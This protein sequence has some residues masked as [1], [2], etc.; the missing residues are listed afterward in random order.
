MKDRKKDNSNGQSESYINFP[1]SYYIHMYVYDYNSR[2]NSC[3]NNPIPHLFKWGCTK[4]KQIF[5]CTCNI[6]V[7]A[8]IF[9]RRKQRRKS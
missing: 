2:K 5:E 6:Y 3:A 7:H 8:F 4:P 9:Q 1:T